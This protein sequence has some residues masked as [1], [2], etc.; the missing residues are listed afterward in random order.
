[1]PN[2]CGAQ[3]GAFDEISIPEDTFFTISDNNFDFV[4]GFPVMVGE[5]DFQF[6]TLALM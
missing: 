2:A 5:K 4:F 3:L 6:F 1:M